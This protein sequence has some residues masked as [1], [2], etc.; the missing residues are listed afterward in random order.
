MLSRRDTHSAR[1]YRSLTLLEKSGKH[2]T[3]QVKVN[4][5]FGRKIEINMVYMEEGK[6][7]KMILRRG[8]E[9]GD[10]RHRKS[11]EA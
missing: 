3:K 8:S 10:F 11:S 2:N 6:E 9:Y 1:R 7:G 5:G 4:L